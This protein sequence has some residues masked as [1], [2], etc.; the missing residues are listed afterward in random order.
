[1]GYF[2]I[3]SAAGVVAAFVG[4]VVLAA[5]GGSARLPWWVPAVLALGFA[6]WSAYAVV[7]DGAVGFWPLHTESPWGVQVF[8][9]LLLMAVVAWF[10]LLPR[11]AAAGLTPWP[12]LV[13]VLSTGSIGMLAALA[14][15]LHAEAATGGSGAPDAVDAPSRSR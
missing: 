1:M 15:L 11:L 14:R 4:C 8:L 13:L 7:T 5:R 9:D 2:E 10:L 3:V 6:G 12:W